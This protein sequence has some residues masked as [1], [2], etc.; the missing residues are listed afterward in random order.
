MGNAEILNKENVFKTN[1]LLLIN[2]LISEIERN[3]IYITEENKTRQHNS[4][5]LQLQQIKRVISK[6][7]RYPHQVAQAIIDYSYGGSNYDKNIKGAKVH[8]MFKEIKNNQNYIPYVEPI[9]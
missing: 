5:V 1:S 4:Y 2:R 7:P 6:D 9:F 3:L 8:L